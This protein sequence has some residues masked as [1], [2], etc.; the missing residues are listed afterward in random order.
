MKTFS[1][2]TRLWIPVIVMA[3]MTLAMSVGA[4]LRTRHLQAIAQATQEAQQKKFELALR[5]R[6]L[7]E[8]NASRV[9]AGLSGSDMSV[10]EAMKADIAKTTEQ[11]SEVQKALE[12]L[13]VADD[14]KAAMARVA[15]KRKAYIDTRN[16]ATKAKA[17][18]QH[19]EGRRV[20]E[21]KVVPAIE[22][23]LGAQQDFVTLQQAKSAELREA[24]GAER[25]RT[26]WGVA[27]V[28]AAIVALL[29]LATGYFVRTISQPLRQLVKEAERIGAGDLRDEATQTRGDEVGDVQRALAQMKQSLRRVIGELRASSDSM[30]TASQEIASGNTDLSHRTEQ[31]A[32][33]LQQAASSLAQ[34]TTTVQQSADSA[35]TANQLAGSAAEV[36]QRGGQVVS[37]VVSTMDEIDASAK[38]IND[39]IGVIDG[40]A[41]QTN[42]LALNAAVEAARAG[43]QGR[44]FAVVAGEVRALAQ[45]SAEAA[46]EIK[47][48]IGNSV[49]KVEAGAQ[50]VQDAGRTMGEIV[51]SVQR[52]SDIIGEISASTVEQSQG[53]ASVNGSVSQLDQMTQQNAA[54]VEESAAAA[55]SLSEQAGKLSHLVSQFQLDREAAVRA[56]APAPRATPASPR[57]TQA[58]PIPASAAVKAPKA[59]TAPRPATARPQ[60]AAPKPVPAA[61]PAPTPK[62]AAAAAAD[63]DWETF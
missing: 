42:I 35:R 22:A 48:L 18:G 20:L 51:A 8:A 1:I 12:A 55:E 47:S 10:A 54:L 24:A 26:V 11:I 4:S 40:I 9:K 60:A 45:R 14:E 37:Q 62:P 53:I 36:A 46:K 16:E 32:S 31:T 34:L 23:Y 43:E 5:W 29:G 50:L 25:M 61:R 2:A 39:I 13:A 49:A 58:A 3:L 56:A 30:Q 17:A 63:G 33:N 7:T 15:D 19:D 57:P 6:G 59:A 44:G 21:Q 38:K 28:M 52:V 41:F 27:A